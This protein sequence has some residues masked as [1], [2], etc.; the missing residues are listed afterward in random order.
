[1]I[2]ALARRWRALAIAGGASLLLL[3]GVARAAEAPPPPLEV[4]E[5][6]YQG[7]A[8]RVTPPELAEALGYMAPLKLKWIGN[9]YSGPQDVQAV[10]TGDID[11][12]GAF[13]GAIA[14]LIAVHAPIK[15]VIAYIGTD[16]DNATGLYVLEDSP[17]KSARDLIGK[18]V[19]MN[20][21]AAYSEYL[22][23]DYL[24]RNGLS[25]EEIKQITLVAGPP[26]NLALLL[27]AKR[28]DATFLQDLA[29][30]KAVE[31]GG[32]RPLTTDFDEYGAYSLASYV[33]T[34]KFIKDNP[35]TLA[36]FV[37]ATARAIEWA[38]TTPRDQ[39][40]ERLRQIVRDRRRNEDVSV[41]DHWK[42]YAVAGRGGLMSDAEFSTYIDW[43]VRTGQLRAGQVKPADVY[44]NRFNPYRSETASR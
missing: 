37:G 6:R 25:G 30:D 27:R 3:A 7:W 13:N 24:L 44:T 22:L 10:V 34:D 1:M 9:T 42:S 31:Q 41:T 15:A 38:R 12:G 8:A 29:R 23:D 11:Y 21:L 16:K 33:F 40:L 36:H 43:Y 39:V 32:I 20:T 17:I 18:T 26:V 35:R 14:K 2:M 4:S 5:L 19:G 28:L